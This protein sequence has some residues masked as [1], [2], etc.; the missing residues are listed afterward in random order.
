MESKQPTPNAELVTNGVMPVQI[1]VCRAIPLPPGTPAKPR[2]DRPA[3]T[4]S[5]EN[6]TENE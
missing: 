5:E 2:P 1:F 4:K 3:F 6:S